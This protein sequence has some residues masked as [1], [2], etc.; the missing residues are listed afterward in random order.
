[1]LSTVIGYA[2]FS[3]CY[4]RWQFPCGSITK[5]YGDT[6]A[7]LFSRWKLYAAFPSVQKQSHGVELR[8]RVGNSY[9]VGCNQEKSGR[10]CLKSIELAPTVKN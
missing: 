6:S 8:C 7:C 9:L 5:L 3:G 4:P 1:M 10:I 2:Q